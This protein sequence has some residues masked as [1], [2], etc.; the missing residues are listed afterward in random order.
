MIGIITSRP[1]IQLLWVLSL[2]R[3]E[4]AL[5][6]GNDGDLSVRVVVVRLSSATSA[7]GFI[8]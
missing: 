2:S 1:G 6:C 3:E 8:T 7:I 5:K 4:V